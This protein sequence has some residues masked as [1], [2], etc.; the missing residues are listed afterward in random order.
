MLD[1]VELVIDDAA[2]RSPLLN[3]QT[4]RLPHVHASRLDA[5]ALPASELRPEILVQRFPLP[6]LPKPERLAG[7]QIAHYRQKLVLFP[8]VDLVHAHLLQRWLAT[9]LVPPFQVALVDRTH[10]GLRQVETPCYLTGGGTLAGF[11][12][13]LF[14]ALA[15]RCLGRQLLDLFHQD[16]AF[17]ASQAMYLHDHS[18]AIY[19]PW[20][21]AD[22]P[23]PHIVHLVQ[24]TA[25]SAALKTPVNRLPPH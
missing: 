20:Q 10:R 2:R 11:P 13:D 19:A 6:F 17:R 23:F 24:A 3:T 21:I 7:F 9:P 25:T 22:L 16:P 15:E 1:D 5:F 4:E 18:R 14:E 8:P 12:H